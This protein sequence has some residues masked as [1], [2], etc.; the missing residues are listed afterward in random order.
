MHWKR[1][2]NTSLWN[3]LVFKG[4]A[5]LFTGL[6]KSDL[7]IFFFFVNGIL[8]EYKYLIVSTSIFFVVTWI[9]I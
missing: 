5:V 2:P 4:R 7:Y 9:A 3:P 8:W 1:Q 6:L